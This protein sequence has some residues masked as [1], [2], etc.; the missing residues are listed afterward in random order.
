MLDTF[1]WIITWKRFSY[2][3]YNCQWVRA[4]KASKL[5]IALYAII[6]IDAHVGAQ[7]IIALRVNR[8]K[9]WTKKSR[10]FLLVN[11]F[12]ER[13]CGPHEFAKWIVSAEKEQ[14][15]KSNQIKS[16]RAKIG[17]HSSMKRNCDLIT[18]SVL[19]VFHRHLHI[20]KCFLTSCFAWSAW[21]HFICT[22]QH[23]NRFVAF[24]TL[25]LH[26]STANVLFSFWVGAAI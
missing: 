21:W 14:W 15:I 2:F 16:Y 13:V 19:V 1:E 22:P 18:G 23:L 8:K 4:R 10:T 11:R 5:A 3:E 20:D 25:A 24:I 12:V 7:E 6:R 17:Q 9:M 26:K